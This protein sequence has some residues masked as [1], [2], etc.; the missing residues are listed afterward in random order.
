MKKFFLSGTVRPERAV[1]DISNLAHEFNS[2]DGKK[3]GLIKF[4]IFKNQI[5][6][7]IEWENEKEDIYTIRNIAKASIELITNV[8]GFLKGYAYD[9]EITKIFDGDLELSFIFGINIPSLEIRNESRDFS[10]ALVN[11]YL[12]CF[13][14]EGVYIRRCLDDL[15]MAIKRLDDTPFH[16]FRA[17]ESLKQYFAFTNNK[18]KESNQQWQ[19]LA[20]AVGR[21]KKYMEPI[22]DLARPARHGIPELI[23]DEIR[24]DILFRTWDIVERFIDYR[25]KI[26]GSNYRLQP[27]GSTKD[28]SDGRMMK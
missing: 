19:A 15:N 12:L 17:V 2:K 21:E 16:C 27:N 25:L 4:N 9:V 26:I 24:K 13:D 5:T 14:S 18:L 11:I 8:V 22:R 6:C 1:L 20:T 28:K 10:S 3:E 7:F 23:T